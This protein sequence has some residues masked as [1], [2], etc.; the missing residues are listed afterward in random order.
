[1][2]YL[3]AMI[4]FHGQAAWRILSKCF[5]QG[6]PS[7]NIVDINWP[8]LKLE[9]ARPGAKNK[10]HHTFILHSSNT[11]HFCDCFL[12]FI[13]PW[14]YLLHH[15]VLAQLSSSLL[16]VRVRS[17]ESFLLMLSHLKYLLKII[18]FAVNNWHTTCWQ[19]L[20]KSLSTAFTCVRVPTRPDSKGT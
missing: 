8:M 1:M 9:N 16:W 12:I 17:C 4:F 10:T 20:L 2:G 18:I 14:S 15:D 5:Q 7:Q 19:T 6:K 13:D 11:G 3:S